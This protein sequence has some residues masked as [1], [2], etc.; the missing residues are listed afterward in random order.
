MISDKET[1]KLTDDEI[2]ENTKKVLEKL[3]Q[4]EMDLGMPSCSLALVRGDKIVWTA[5]Y[6]YANIGQK[7]LATPDT[8]YPTGSTLKSVTATALL[9]LVDQGKCKLNDPVNKY[10][11]DHPV[12]DDPKDAV[13]LRHLLDQTSGLSDD[14]GQEWVN[15]WDPARPK[16]HSLEE[17]ADSMKSV[18]PVGKT[19]RYNNSAFAVAGLVIANISGM[20]YEDYIIK[21]VLAPLGATT[22]RPI[23]P[24][25]AMVEMMALPYDYDSKDTIQP[26]PQATAP[27][28]PSGLAYLKA[29]DMARF[30]GAHLNEGVFNGNRIIWL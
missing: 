27:G 3:I 7:A 5:A 13:T 9:T 28:Y 12:K 30:L 2:L 19:W 24:T 17:I 10:L 20:S 14:L 23:F 25:P 16:L 11:G 8:Y 29:E 22:T 1:K 26:L 15:R 6:G 21:K 4:K 18:E